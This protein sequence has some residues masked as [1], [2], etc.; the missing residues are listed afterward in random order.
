MFIGIEHHV[1]RHFY[2]QYFEAATDIVSTQ[3][4]KIGHPKFFVGRKHSFDN[5]PLLH[6]TQNMILN[7]YGIHKENR[8]YENI[9]I[10]GVSPFSTCVQRISWIHI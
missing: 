5:E 3:M 6:N 7:V 1:R 4:I 9:T 8:T 2:F 10:L